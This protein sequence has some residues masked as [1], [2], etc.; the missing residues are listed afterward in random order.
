MTQKQTLLISVTGPESTGK[1]T[2][3]Q[4]LK[5]TLPNAHSVLE[6]ARIYMEQEGRVEAHSKS[7]V[8]D[9][10]EGQLNAI[11]A[12]AQGSPLYIITDTDDVMFWIWLKEVFGEVPA[13]WQELS[14]EFEPDFTLL[15]APDVPWEYDPLRVNPH[16]RDRLFLHYESRLRSMNRSFAVVQGLESQRI[17]NA[18]HALHSAGIIP[19]A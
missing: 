11:R 3:V 19:N 16:D 6:F 15:C 9:M 8:L 5:K 12:A 18:L 1:T 14:N 7:D 4:A 17:E 10:M 2:L 13:R